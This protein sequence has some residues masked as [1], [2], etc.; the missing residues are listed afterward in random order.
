MSANEDLD[1]AINAAR[2]GGAYLKDRFFAGARAE[3]EHGRDIKLK[4]DREAQ[5][6]IIAALRMSSSLPVIAE[7][8]EFHSDALAVPS[9]C[10]I[11]D[12]L[13]GSLN[14][15]RGIPLCAS[16]I[17]LWRDGRAVVAV[18]YDFL[19][20]KLYAADDSG[21]TMNGRRMTVA[22]TKDKKSA[23][24]S[25]GLPVNR[26]YSPEALSAMASE[27]ASYK[28]VRMFGSA[29]TSLALVA[30]G[31][32]DVYREEGVM[33][34]DVAAGLLLVEAAGGVIRMTK[35]DRAAFAYDVVAAANANLL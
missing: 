34:W 2:V 35:S 32:T 22:D 12:P 3:S 6:R 28:K 24:L 11:V 30:S 26:D 25:T 17:A 4:E 19:G 20:D 18:I 7:E 31:A 23:V 10:W 15:K 27:F 29:A 5:E 1:V 8:D 9:G 33:L 14:F 13:D 21:A 16:A